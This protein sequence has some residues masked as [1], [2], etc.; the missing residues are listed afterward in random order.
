MHGQQ[1]EVVGSCPA[2][3]EHAG[4]G[5]MM[6]FPCNKTPIS[7]LLDELSRTAPPPLLGGYH[8]GEQ[9]FFTGSSQDT[10]TVDRLVHGQRGEVVGPADAASSHAAPR[11]GW[12]GHPQRAGRVP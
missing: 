6:L 8:L 5:L 3:S 7:C 11:V 4:K 12:P 1:A 10:A 9:L 2:S